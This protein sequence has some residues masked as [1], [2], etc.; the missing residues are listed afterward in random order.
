MEYNE[1]QFQCLANK[2]ALTMWIIVE[3]ILT[4]AYIIEVAGG[5]KE[6]DFLI[7]FLIL[8]WIPVIIGAVM[9]KVKGMHTQI[10]KEII[11]VGYGIFFTYVMFTAETAITF[12]Y[13]FPI[14]GMMIL[15]KNK[16]L[17]LRIEGANILVIIA[18]FVKL[19]V[20]RR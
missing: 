10:F 11:A 5:K 19:R 16:S 8:G 7:V 2:L 17:L 14:A 18:V 20:S 6:V 9:L 15:Y 1:K 3:A 12:S 4:V 13:V